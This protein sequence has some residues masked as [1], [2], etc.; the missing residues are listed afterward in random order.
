MQG[1]FSSSQRCILISLHILLFTIPLLYNT[2]VKQD[3]GCCFMSSPSW[4]FYDLIKGCSEG[5]QQISTRIEVISNQVTPSH[6]KA[7]TNP[8]SPV[9]QLPKVVCWKD[10]AAGYLSFGLMQSLIC[11]IATTLMQHKYL[12]FEVAVDNELPSLSLGWSD[13]DNWKCCPQSLLLSRLTS[14][15]MKT[16]PSQKISE[17]CWHFWS[18]TA[19]QC[20]SSWVTVLLDA[21]DSCTT[22][23]LQKV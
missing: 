6:I 23:I 1:L 12:P 17:V 20:V 5:C 21:P 18:D 2:L 16:V 15:F 13:G 8:I 19:G 11:G 3:T 10:F 4:H 22:L 9:R 7:G 14:L